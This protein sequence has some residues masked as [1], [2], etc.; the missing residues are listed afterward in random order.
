MAY[1][2]LQTDKL[3]MK[4]LSFFQTSGVLFVYL[5]VKVHYFHVLSCSYH[6]FFLMINKLN[7][8]ENVSWKRMAEIESPVYAHDVSQQHA[9]EDY[10]K[11]S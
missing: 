1:I 3:K 9:Q 5:N 10:V 6:K 11:H 2:D 7:L 4:M 8:R